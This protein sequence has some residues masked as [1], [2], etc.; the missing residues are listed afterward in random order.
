[1]NYSALFTHLSRAVICAG[2]LFGTVTPG[3][4]ARMATQPSH[5]DPGNARFDQMDINKDGRVI[6]EE[7]TAAFPNMND[8]AFAVIDLNKDGA[9]ERE[10]WLQFTEGH[11]KGQMPGQR[12]RGA[13]MNNIP[14]DPLIP[15]PDSADLPLMRPP[16]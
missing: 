3:C 12:D 15:P 2:I 5:V 13:P 7:F 11:A 1:M 10:E 6:L 4:A 14:G 9:I 16:M 8:Q